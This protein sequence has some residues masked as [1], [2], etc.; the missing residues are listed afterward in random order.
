MEDI[1]K[2]LAK[3]IK[4]HK[5]IGKGEQGVIYDFGK[6]VM[7]VTKSKV[8]KEL[9]ER[10]SSAGISPK[11]S[12]I[13]ECDG[14]TYIEMENMTERFT[15]SKYGDQMGRL[16][17]QMIKAKVFHNDIH[18]ENLMA[19]NGR[20]YFIDFDNSTLIDD[21]TKKEF[22]K[23]FKYHTSFTDETYSKRIPIAFT[24]AQMKTIMN[25]RNSLK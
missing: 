16:V 17:S 7:K 6:T 13:H 22:D 14:L 19:K 24:K 21:M 2:E 11:I 1:C 15:A 5:R 12:G 4:K 9:L 23:E 20:L 3:D 18:A 25:V 10:V 8:N